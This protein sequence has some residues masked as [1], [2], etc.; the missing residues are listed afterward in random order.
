MQQRPGRLGRDLAGRRRGCRAPRASDPARRRRCRP[1]AGRRRRRAPTG[2]ARAPGCARPRAGRR[3]R[4]RRAVRRGGAASR[5]GGRPGPRPGHPVRWTSAMIRSRRRARGLGV[6]GA[7][8]DAGLDDPHLVGHVAQPGG[9]RPPRRTPRPRRAASP[10]RPRSAS[11]C[12]LAA[13]SRAR[14]CG[15]STVDGVEQAESLLGGGQGVEGA[16]GD[17]GG[18]GQRGQQLG[19]PGRVGAGRHDGP[20]GPRAARAP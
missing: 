15:W 11:A 5:G 13:S 20:A 7:L 18:G 4:P 9:Q 12:T 14:I 10:S 17:A 8:E 3:R 2:R 16:L 19:P 1:A 6:A